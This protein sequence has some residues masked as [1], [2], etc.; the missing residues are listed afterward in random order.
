M[1]KILESI[2]D[3]KE[4]VNLNNINYVYVYKFR[5]VEYGWLLFKVRIFLLWFI[6]EKINNEIIV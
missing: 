1:L 3:M 4:L 6:L 5:I 2:V